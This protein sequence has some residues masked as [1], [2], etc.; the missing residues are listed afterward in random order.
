MLLERVNGVGGADF[1]TRHPYVGLA[2]SI[3]LIGNVVWHM[4]RQ[5]SQVVAGYGFGFRVKDRGVW[6]VA[7]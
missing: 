7:V 3:K 5:Q 1:R 2:I 6:V 4:R